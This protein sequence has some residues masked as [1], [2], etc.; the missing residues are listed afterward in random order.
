MKFAYIDGERVAV[1][2]PTDAKL[3]VKIAREAKTQ[4]D[5]DSVFEK[6]GPHIY[7]GWLSK[8]D[9]ES[10]R[11][12]VLS[13]EGEAVGELQPGD[14]FLSEGSLDSFKIVKAGVA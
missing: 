2:R 5:L 6:C 14:S 12:S 11:A 4:E 9:P 8:P 3:A 13:H 1:L 7:V 10:G